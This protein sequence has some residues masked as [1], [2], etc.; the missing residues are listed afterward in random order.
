ME[1]IEVCCPQSGGEEHFSGCLICGAELVYNSL[2]TEQ[3]C[4][5]CGRTELDDPNLEFRYCSK[6]QGNYEYCMDHI[7]THIHVRTG[8]PTCF[9][10]DGHVRMIPKSETKPQGE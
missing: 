10:K 1:R 3:R 6:C 5:V 7:F 9:D 8:D 2:G 4:A